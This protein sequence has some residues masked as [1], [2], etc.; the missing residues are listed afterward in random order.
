MPLTKPYS[1]A[2]AELSVTARCV[3]DQCLIKWAPRSATPADVLRLV[4]KHPAKSISTKQ[5]YARRGHPFQIAHQALQGKLT[6][7]I[8]QRHAAAQF[9]SGKGNVSAIHAQI[10][11][12]CC[13]R[14]E[15]SR[16]LCTQTTL[17]VCPP[18]PPSSAPRRWT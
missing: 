3:L 8:R 18:G 14:S 11:A 7:C 17:P 9:F 15:D 5:L 2:S 1:F 6:G 10:I 16:V 12:A 13:I 4:V